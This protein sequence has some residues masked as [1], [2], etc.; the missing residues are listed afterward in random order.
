MASFSMDVK[1]PASGVFS[2]I[3]HC[4]GTANY[5]VK[6]IVQNQSVIAEGARDFSW[7]IIIILALVFWPA[8][9]VYYFTRQRSSITATINKDSE[10]ECSITITSNGNT[11][12]NLIKLIENVLQEGKSKSED[13]PEN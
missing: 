5:K 13:K 7:I 1:M 9:L 10:N 6:T 11:G 4:I 12:E 8:A 3:Q 2:E